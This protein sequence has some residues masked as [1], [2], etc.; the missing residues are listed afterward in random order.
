MNK[1]LNIS[2]YFYIFL[3]TVSM[4]LKYKC[5]ECGIPLGF[6]GLCWRCRAKKHREEVDNWTDKEI[7]EKINQVIEKLKVSTED[8]FMKLMSMKF[9]KI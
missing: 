4:S 8:N 3:A 6:E 5:P 9:F 2:I 1:E 7:E